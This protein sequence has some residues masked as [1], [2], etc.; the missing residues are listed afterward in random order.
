MLH[1]DPNTKFHTHAYSCTHVHTHTHKHTHIREKERQRVGQKK[2]ETKV[3]TAY[4]DIIKI[5]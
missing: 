2:I 5:I 4:L 3:Q 1:Q